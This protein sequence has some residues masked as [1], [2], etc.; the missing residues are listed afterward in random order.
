VRTLLAIVLA[1]GA[2]GAPAVEHTLGGTKAARA[3]LLAAADL[4]EGWTGK[5]SLQ[6]GVMFA[7]KGYRPSGAGVIETG[8]ATSPTLSYSSVGPFI[9]QKTSVYATPREAATYWRRAVRPGLVACAVQNVEDLR[10]RGL[11]VKIVGKAKLPFS[12]AVDRAAAYR[13]TAVANRLPLYFDVILLGRGRTITSVAISS[14]Q[15]APPPNFEQ[16]LARV[17]ARKLRGPSA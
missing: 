16:L 7:C 14:F 3:S 6:T 2:T 1:A 4:G 10:S 15:Q 17:I 11:D 12:S 5:P 13:V 9:S 8:A